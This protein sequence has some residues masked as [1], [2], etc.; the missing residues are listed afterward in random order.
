MRRSTRFS[1]SV[2]VLRSKASTVLG[3]A[4]VSF[5]TFGCIHASIK[6]AIGQLKAKNRL[7]SLFA[8][9]NLGGCLCSYF[10][11]IE[12]HWLF[13][14]SWNHVSGTPPS[15]FLQLTQII[16]YKSEIISVRKQRV[17]VQPAWLSGHG[18]LLSILEHLVKVVPSSMWLP[19][20][21]WEWQVL[22]VGSGTR[23]CFQLTR[24]FF[25]APHVL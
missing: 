15:R 8:K 6:K 9:S 16:S 19:C 20:F 5:R 4:D 21:R 18:Q 11:H 17:N 2:F 10:G 7:G 3:E 25:S 13:C 24:V 12:L 22:A 1:F 14:I 23:K